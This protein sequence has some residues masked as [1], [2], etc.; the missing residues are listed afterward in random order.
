MALGTGISCTQQLPV[1]TTLNQCLLRGDVILST[2]GKQSVLDAMKE[3]ASLT[4]RMKDALEKRDYSEIPSLLNRNFDLRCEVCADAI[5][6]KNRQMVELA[7]KTGASAKFTGSGGAIIGTYEDEKMFG[8][9]VRT[10]RAFQ[11][12]VIK[13]VIV[14]NQKDAWK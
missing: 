10:L 5:S 7:R 2:E 9:L 12:D 6:R 1:V 14:K 4:D 11:I 3:W 8:S 13:P